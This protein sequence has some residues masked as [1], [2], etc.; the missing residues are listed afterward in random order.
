MIQVVS[1]ENVGRKARVVLGDQTGVVK[2]YLWGDENLKVGAS[3]VIFKAEAPVVKEH[4][5]IQ[6][7]RGKI[8][9][10]RR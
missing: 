2:A 6:L 3:I 7:P 10:A 5:E 9:I 4:I 1:V 8:D